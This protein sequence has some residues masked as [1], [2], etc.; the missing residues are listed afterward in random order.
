[1]T[2][3][4][5]I[6]QPSRLR[7]R[8]ADTAENC[9]DGGKCDEPPNL[10]SD[11]HVRGPRPLARREAEQDAEHRSPCHPAE[12][13][14]ARQSPARRPHGYPLGRMSLEQLVMQSQD[15]PQAPI[16]APLT[17]PL[18]EMKPYRPRHWPAVP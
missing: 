17:E 18:I 12:Q 5:S 9:H 16:M 15:S 1:M 10:V 7:R 14:S 6:R 2:A 3:P 4:A 8:P 11:S 13:P